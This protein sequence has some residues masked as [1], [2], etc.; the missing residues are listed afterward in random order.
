MLRYHN[1]S[2]KQICIQKWHQEIANFLDNTY[3]PTQK[4]NITQLWSDEI[5]KLETIDNKTVTAERDKGA[6]ET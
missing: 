3:T 6:Q 2:Q 5:L 1:C 4:D